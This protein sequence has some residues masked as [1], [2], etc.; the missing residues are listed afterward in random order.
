VEEPRAEE[1]PPLLV[2]TRVV[3]LSKDPLV[4]TV[5]GGWRSKVSA[6]RTSFA[7]PAPLPREEKACCSGWLLLLLGLIALGGILT[8]ILVGKNSV[9]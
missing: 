9:S 1:A 7:A 6:S 2:N 5:Q 3:R 8:A 4:E